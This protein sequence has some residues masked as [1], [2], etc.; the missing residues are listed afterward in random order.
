MQRMCF[1]NRFSTLMYRTA[2]HLY[3]A[4]HPSLRP[5]LAHYTYCLPHPE[6]CPAR[7]SR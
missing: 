3:L 4:P 6:P 5:Y 7:D 1:S 2:T